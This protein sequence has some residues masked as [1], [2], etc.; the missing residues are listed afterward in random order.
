MDSLHFH[1]LF[2][3]NKSDTVSLREPDRLASHGEHVLKIMFTACYKYQSAITT[4]HNHKM[5]FKKNIGKGRN[6]GGCKFILIPSAKR[7]MR[8]WNTIELNADT[9]SVKTYFAFSSEVQITFYS[10]KYLLF[11]VSPLPIQ[12]SEITFL[13]LKKTVLSWDHMPTIIYFN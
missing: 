6:N 4:W 1:F 10:W 3:S 2:H 9:Q 11:K 13:L 7:E 12:F 8:A 5:Y